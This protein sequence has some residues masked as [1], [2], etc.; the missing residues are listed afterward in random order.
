ML[1]RYKSGCELAV[2]K[3]AE[4]RFIAIG[5]RHSRNFTSWIYTGDSYEDLE[6]RN[7]APETYREEHGESRIRS[8]KTL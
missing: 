5:G 2:K 7:D 6:R 1:G 4:E 8:P 3:D